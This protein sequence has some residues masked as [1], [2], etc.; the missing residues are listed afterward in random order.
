MRRHQALIKQERC[1]VVLQRP[2]TF[3][4]RLGSNPSSGVNEVKMTAEKTK[5]Q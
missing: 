5:W 4:G 2:V 3:R 1:A